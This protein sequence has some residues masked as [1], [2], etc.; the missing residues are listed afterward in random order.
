MNVGVSS[1]ASGL[2][3]LVGMWSGPVALPLCVVRFFLEGRRLLLPIQVQP[4]FSAHNRTLD[5]LLLL[6]ILGN[7]Y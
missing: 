5:L 1:S 2:S 4:A 3:S 6:P 7:F